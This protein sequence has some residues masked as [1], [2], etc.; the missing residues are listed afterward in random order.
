MLFQF[1]FVAFA[2][3][4]SSLYVMIVLRHMVVL[5]NIYGPA[6]V[7]D[8]KERVRFK[9]LFYKILQVLCV[10]LFYQLW[11]TSTILLFLICLLLSL[12]Y[13][14]YACLFFQCLLETMGIFAGTWKESLC[15]W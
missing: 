11:N 14:S 4:I 9:L 1:Y 12:G 10:H 15:C 7:E 6:V 3:T 13:A 8:D 5:F 2:Y